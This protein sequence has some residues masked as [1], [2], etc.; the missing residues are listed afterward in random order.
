MRDPVGAG[1]GL[2]VMA[3][4]RRLRTVASD[5]EWIRVGITSVTVLEPSHTCARKENTLRGDP[6][7]CRRQRIGLVH[8]RRNMMMRHMT[9]LALASALSVGAAYPSVAAPVSSINTALKAAMIDNVMA[10]RWHG[11]HW[12]FGYRHHYGRCATREGGGRYRTC[13]TI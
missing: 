1:N 12:R 2:V 11:W 7:R 8:R 4:L 10:V 3:P 6:I 9:L 13:D 5:T